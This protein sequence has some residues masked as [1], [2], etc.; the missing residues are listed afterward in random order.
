MAP[1]KTAGADG[2][3][4]NETAS[5]VTGMKA[6]AGYLT[7]L[8]NGINMAGTAAEDGSQEILNHSVKQYPAVLLPI[9]GNCPGNG[10]VAPAVFLE[11]AFAGSWQGN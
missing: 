10:Y 6:T 4:A 7:L 11:K 1:V 2:S 3:A 8:K 9:N 5:R